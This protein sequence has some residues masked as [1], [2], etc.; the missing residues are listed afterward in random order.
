[1][2]QVD[3]DQVIEALIFK[4]QIFGHPFYD[5]DLRPALAPCPRRLGIWRGQIE[6]SEVQTRHRSQRLR[7]ETPGSTRKIED[8]RVALITL[9]HFANEFSK[10]ST[11][12][13]IC[14]ASK[15]RFDLM[16]VNFCTVFAQPAIG[17]IVE[18]LT[19][20]GWK[21]LG[22]SRLMRA[23]FDAVSFQP[24]TVDV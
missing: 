21:A 11:A 5:F 13:G 20:I 22:I 14:R 6:A 17:L 10:R 16:I 1:M 23:N 2:E 4:R 9:S 18:V 3:R 8:L 12:H 15:Q 19:V 7:H 24:P